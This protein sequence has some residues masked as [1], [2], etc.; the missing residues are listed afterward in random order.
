MTDE[1]PYGVDQDA[2]DRNEAGTTSPY[3][4]LVRVRLHIAKKLQ[5]Q[6]YNTFQCDYR[7]VHWSAFRGTEY[8]GAH[9]GIR[10]RNFRNIST[11]VLCT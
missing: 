5:S 8:Q 6:V 11:F 1:D 7:I 3:H 4:P 10:P 9:A 2:Y